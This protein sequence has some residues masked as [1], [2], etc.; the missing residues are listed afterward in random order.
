M[1]S[2]GM[3]MKLNAINHVR[4]KMHNLYVLIIVSLS[5]YDLMHVIEE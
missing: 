3:T 1:T 5:K 2:S 4:V